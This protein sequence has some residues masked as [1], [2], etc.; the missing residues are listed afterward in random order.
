MPSA[1]SNPGP[2]T[3][4]PG[5]SAGFGA[6]AEDDNR[7]LAQEEFSTEQAGQRREL[8]FNTRGGA[9]RV[10]SGKAGGDDGGKDWGPARQEVPVD[11]AGQSRANFSRRSDFLVVRI[12][13]I[14]LVIMDNGPLVVGG[15]AI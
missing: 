6:S 7:G 13:G 2:L 8:F 9:A 5:G 10:E 1:V 15:V 4:Q 12:H 14:C 11:Q 3:P